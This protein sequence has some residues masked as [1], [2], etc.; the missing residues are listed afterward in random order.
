MKARR[1]VRRYYMYHLKTADMPCSA[2]VHLSL[3][4]SSLL[5]R[6]KKT[7]PESLQ[8]FDVAA[9]RTSEL[10]NLVFSRQTG[11]F[12]C[13]HLFVDKPMVINEPTV[14]SARLLGLGKKLYLS[15]GWVLRN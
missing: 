4:L 1:S 13:A 15:A 2:C 7:L 3:L 12:K 9:A 11:F 14:A 8:A 5:R 6:R 10:V